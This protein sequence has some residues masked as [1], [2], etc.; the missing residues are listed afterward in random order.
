MRNFLLSFGYVFGMAITFSVLGMIA[1]MTGKL[2]GQIQSSPI[3]HLVVGNVMILF[4][5]VL[6][7]IIH[8]PTFLLS[9][10]GAGKVVKGGTMFSAILMGIASGFIATPCTAAVLAALLTF[11]ATTQN[12]IFGSTLLFVFAIGLGT[13]LII[14]GTF[15]GI[16]AS[17]PRSEKVMHIMQK[18]LALAMILVGEYFIFKAGMLN[19]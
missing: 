15:T 1:A 10:T 7:D 12:I 3:A 2:F 6:L 8:M 4:A 18:V 9:R 13:L 14:I 11:T 16:L 19:F 5:L 17:I